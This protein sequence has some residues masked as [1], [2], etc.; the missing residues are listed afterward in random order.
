[1]KQIEHL[2]LGGHEIFVMWEYDARAFPQSQLLTSTRSNKILQKGVASLN[3]V[4]RDNL[5]DL[6]PKTIM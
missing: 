3:L 2:W 1:M 5:W 4:F 6:F